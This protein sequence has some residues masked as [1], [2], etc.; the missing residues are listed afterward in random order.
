[1]YANSAWGE[2]AVVDDDGDKESPMASTSAF[3]QIWE[4]SLLYQWAC[5]VTYIV[6]IQ[7][8]LVEGFFPQVRLLLSKAR[9]E[10]A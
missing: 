1:M 6:P 9:L 10:G 5:H 4:F 8:Q 2:R 3:R 7:Q